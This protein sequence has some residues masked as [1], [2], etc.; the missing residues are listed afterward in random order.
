MVLI[1]LDKNT[2]PVHSKNESRFFSR[3]VVLEW[4]ANA[5]LNYITQTL[6]FTLLGITLLLV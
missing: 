4:N 1:S 6:L 2:F 3:S 5:Q